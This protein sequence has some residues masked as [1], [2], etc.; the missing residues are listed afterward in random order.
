MSWKVVWLPAQIAGLVFS[1]LVW[2]VVAGLSLDAA[3]AILVAGPWG[4]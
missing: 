4:C 1:S 2:I 3:A